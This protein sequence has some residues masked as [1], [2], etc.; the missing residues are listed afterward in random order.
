MRK[1]IFLAATFAVAM[2]WATP[3]KAETIWFDTNGAAFGGQVNA[4][5]FDWLPG[6][7]LIIENAA[8]TKATVLFQA[9]LGTVVVPAAPDYTNGSNGYFYTAV[10]GFSVDITKL[11][12]TSTFTFDA[13]GATNFFKIYATTAPDIA[14]D[15]ANDLS[16]AGFTNGIE[17][18]S[19]TALAT[20]FSSSLT[21]TNIVGGALDQFGSNNYPLISSFLGTGST[22]VQ[23]LVDT[24]NPNYF[25]NLDP[26]VTIQ[27]T[28]TSQVDPYNQANPS[29]FFNSDGV[30]AAD[31]LGVDP[32]GVSGVG[33]YNGLCVNGNVAITPCKIVA[34]SDAN[35]SFVGLSPIPEPATLSLLGL[36]LLGSAAARRRK[37]KNAKQ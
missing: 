29:N 10:A 27:F 15:G 30:G 13:A 22:A 8:G 12:A 23:V 9:N 2:A 26:G 28:N 16:G 17:I 31:T 18:L 34:Q 32:T 11:G 25:K 3:S 14:G 20:G 36:G 33:T 7:S 21:V 1:S 4:D 6:N 19:G 24:F 35:T 37:L 5:L